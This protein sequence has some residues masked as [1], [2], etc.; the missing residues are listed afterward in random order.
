[1]AG[2]FFLHHAADHAA[3]RT[4]GSRAVA[5]LLSCLFLPFYDREATARTLASAD[6]VVSATGCFDL[7]FAPDPSVIDMVEAVMA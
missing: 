6:R 4:G 3:T 1:L 2:L 7:R 5:Q